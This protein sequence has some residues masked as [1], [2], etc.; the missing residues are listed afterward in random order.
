MKHVSSKWAHMDKD[1]KHPY[2]DM[3]LKDKQRYEREQAEF[4]QAHSLEGEVTSIKD[5]ND[6]QEG[7]EHYYDMS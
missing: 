3:A 1:E 4:I 6:Q 5:D 2:N 7:E